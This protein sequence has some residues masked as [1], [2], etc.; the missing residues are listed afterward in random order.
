MDSGLKLGAAFFGVAGIVFAVLGYA[1]KGN[2]LGYFVSAGVCAV[3][4]FAMFVV[5]PKRQSP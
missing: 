2:P 1:E 5:G 4:L 3:I